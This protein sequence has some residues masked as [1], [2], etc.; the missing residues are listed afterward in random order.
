[1]DD[2]YHNGIADEH[3]HARTHAPK[4]FGRAFAIGVALN[5]GFVIIE[6]IRR[7]ALEWQQL[8]SEPQLGSMITNFLHPTKR[9]KNSEE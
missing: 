5:T 2:N 1:M 9:R 4:D 3:D 7:S 6:A 8:C